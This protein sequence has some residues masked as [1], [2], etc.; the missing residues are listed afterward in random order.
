MPMI[1]HV[2]AVSRSQT[3][4]HRAL[5]QSLNLFTTNPVKAL[6]FAILV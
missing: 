3:W 2:T 4:V 1:Q 5:V 6:H